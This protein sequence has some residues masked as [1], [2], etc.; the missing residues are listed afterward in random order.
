MRFQLLVLQLSLPMAA[1]VAQV[2]ETPAV[3]ARPAALVADGIPPVPAE[4]AAATRPYMEFRT[5]TFT[6]WNNRDRSMLITTRFGNT[7]QLHRVA[8][9]LGYRQQLS[10]EEEPVTGTWSPTGDMLVAQKDI[11]G[12][13]FFQLHTLATGGLQLLTD[14][15]SRNEFGA[16]SHDGR[17]VGYSSTRRNGTDTD[18]YVVDPR[19]RATDRMVAQVQGGGWN[20]LDFSLTAAAPSSSTIIRSPIRTSTCSISRAAR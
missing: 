16:W 13:E 2:P 12:S 19:D 1:A 15:R 11:G 3:V 17:L 6:G 14:G 8:A 4:L 20:I 9:P 5:A 18:L 10:F 7:A